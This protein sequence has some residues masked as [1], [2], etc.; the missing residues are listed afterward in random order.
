MAPWLW[1]VGGPNGAG[2]TSFAGQF[3]DSLSRAFPNSRLPAHFTRLNA[4]ERTLA[5][6][7][8]FPD[9]ARDSLNLRA[10]RDIDAEL[11]RL[12]EAGETVA[13]ET[14]LSSSKYRDDVEAA[15]ARGYKIG[16]IYV[17]LHPPELSPRR[18]SERVAKGGH[19]V[20]P[21][22]AIERYHRSHSQ[23]RWFA[24]RADFLLVFDNSDNQPGVP[25]E[26]LAQRLPGRPMHRFKR[27][28]NP[29][30]D[31]ALDNVTHFISGSGSADP[32]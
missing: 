19:A 3:L 13:V 29:A 25:P 30:V 31:A 12:I 7:Q 23:L 20:D 6:R 21:I 27:G 22:R 32:A 15:Q 17:S 8:Q 14:V 9:A 1:I 2:K 11:V 16:L 28:A 24:A 18:V 5:L 10:A 26:L 4:D